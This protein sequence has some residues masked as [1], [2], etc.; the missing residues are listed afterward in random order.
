MTDSQTALSDHDFLKALLDIVIP[1]SAS[2]DLP[3]A[4]SLGLESA[5]EEGVHADPVLGPP[6]EPG[7][8]AM[9]DAA[10]A[11]HADGL[12][13]MSLEDATALAEAHLGSNPMVMM[14]LLRHLYPAYY[15]HAKVLE[16]IGEPPRPPFPD[17]FEV[18]PTDPELL[19]K[20]QTRAKRA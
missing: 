12:S 19:E 20:L 7:L 5:V 10:L 15:G 18:E 13:G 6:V 1:P 16:G 4:G 8:Q 17:G 11:E 3:G 14:G 9:R 2:G